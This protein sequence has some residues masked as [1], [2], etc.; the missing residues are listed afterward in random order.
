LPSF[1][2][3]IYRV[4]RLIEYL[5]LLVG[6]PQ[7]LVRLHIESKTV[8]PQILDVHCSL[9]PKRSLSSE[10]E[11]PSSFD[12]LL[13]GARSPQEFSSILRRW[14]DR[15]REWHDARWRFFNSFAQQ[16]HYDIDRLIASANMFDILPDSAVP[17][18]VLLTTAEEAA[19]SESRRLFRA[20]PATPQRDSV[21][22]ALGRMGKSSLKHK[23]RHR[24]QRLIDSSGQ[25]FPQLLMVTEEAVNCRNYYVHGSTPRFDYDKNFDLV[26]FLTDT[27]EFVFAVSD[28]IDAGWDLQSWI[29]RPTSMTHPFGGYR[30]AY[31]QALKSLS[32][33]LLPPT[34][35]G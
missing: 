31:N 19:Q 24:A 17:P 16:R 26:I 21:L 6:R 2:E 18:D 4:H 32:S 35:M 3:T 10:R 5:G 15:G 27:L 14:L 8:P 30:I 11:K 7:N 34:S 25:A 9:P 1:R 13:D 33:A 20:L 28:L 23:V 12:V 22:G 29:A